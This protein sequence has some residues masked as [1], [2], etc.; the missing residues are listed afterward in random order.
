M[1]YV[2][3]YKTLPHLCANFHRFRDINILIFYIKTVG[4]VSQDNFR[5]VVIRWGKSKSTQVKPYNVAEFGI[6]FLF[7]ANKIVK[8]VDLPQTVK[9]FS[10]DPPTSHTDT[11]TYRHIYTPTHT[12][13]VAREQN[14]MLCISPKNAMPCNPNKNALRH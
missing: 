4:K 5:N 1:A 13:L 14:A 2:K 8:M 9:Q 11:N 6:L 7:V 10:F 12:V 3:I